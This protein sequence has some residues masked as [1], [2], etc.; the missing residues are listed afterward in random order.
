VATTHIRKAGYKGIVPFWPM[1]DTYASN[2]P[3]KFRD[4]VEENNLEV[5]VVIF[6]HNSLS[7]YKKAVDFLV[8]SETT[9]TFC[10]ITSPK[11]G[12]SSEEEME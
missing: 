6:L 11:S 9:N 8:K 4:L 7:N 3:S 10:W 5:P 12:K 1:I 2:S